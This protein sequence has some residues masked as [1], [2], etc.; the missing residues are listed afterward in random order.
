MKELMIN[1]F[2]YYIFYRCTASPIKDFLNHSNRIIR[3]I[4]IS[5]QKCISIIT[6]LPFPSITRMCS[7]SNISTLTIMGEV[8]LQT[9]ALKVD[10]TGEKCQRRKR[11]WCQWVVPCP[12]C[13]T[14]LTYLT[15][16]TCP[17]YLTCQ[18]YPACLICLPCPICLTYP[19]YQASQFTI[20]DS[21]RF[22]MRCLPP[23][24][25]PLIRVIWPLSHS[26]FS[27]K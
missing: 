24:P 13:Q 7:N 20:P 18:I 11:W 12:T 9:I 21:R 6:I 27:H 10:T 15:C 22:T 23:N 17:T 2:F 3:P 19:I 1:I 4:I 14:Y 8:S 16:P 25:S 26:S 5:S